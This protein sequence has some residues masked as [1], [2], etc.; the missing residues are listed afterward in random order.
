MSVGP[1]IKN[2]THDIA[3]TDG[4]QFVGL[5]GSA[6]ELG[7]NP[8]EQTSLKTT[9]GNQSYSDLE[10]PYMVVAQDDWTGGRAS[11]EFERDVTRYKDGLRVNTERAGGVILYGRETYC[12][13]LRDTDESLPGSMRLIP[14]TESRRYLSKQF[15]AGANKDATE[16]WFWVRRKGT[17]NGALTIALYSD[18]SG[19]IDSELQSTTLAVTDLDPLVSEHKIFS[20]T[21]E[22]ITD[23]TDYWVLIAGA[24]GDDDSD[25]WE[26]GASGDSGTTKKSSDG[27]TWASDTIDLYFRV[28]EGDTQTGGFWIEYKKGWYFITRPNDGTTASKLYLNGSR[29]LA[30]SNAGN[31][32]KLIASAAHGLTAAQATGAVVM[33]IEGTGSTEEQNWR[34]ITGVPT[35]TQFSVDKDWLIEHDATTAWVVLGTDV[36]TEIDWSANVTKPVT[37]AYVSTQAIAYFCQGEEDN[38]VRMKEEVDGGAWVRTFADD[39]VT[40]AI[41]LTEYNNAGTMYLVG[42]N[43]DGK[44]K[45]GATPTSWANWAPAA[46]VAV[47]AKWDRFTGAC[48]YKDYE[49]E[50]IAVLFKEGGPWQWK[51]EVADEMNTPEMAA[52]ASYK[53]GLACWRQSSYL[54]F[55]VQNTIWRFYNPNFDDVGP[56][57][58]EGLPVGRQGN[59][60]F[61]VAY[62][63]RIIVGID[64]GESGYSSVMVNSGGTAFHEM[65]R[66]PYG[67]RITAGAFQI[68]PGSEPDRLWIRQGADVV[69]LPFPSETYDPYQDSNYPF[70]HEFVLEL[71]DI[72]AGLYDAWKYWRSLKLRTLNLLESKTTGIRTTWLEC[73]YRTNE[74]DEWTTLREEFTVSP[75][76]EQDLDEE[77]G[78]SSQVIYMR[79]RGYSIDTSE[80]PKLTAA[81]ISGV[82]ITSPKFSYQT[83][84]ICSDRDKLGNAEDLEPWEKVKILDDW[85]GTARPLRL[86]STN[87]LYNNIAVFLM[88]LPVRPRA[89]AQLVNE[90]DYEVSLVLQEA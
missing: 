85:S 2:P 1:D 39:D 46:G 28:T 74:D 80:T 66:A 37:C 40:T 38:I 89:S 32:D 79:I 18:D 77:Y 16:L 90:H 59:I 88:P 5:L 33:V 20:I 84:A 17:P 4:K 72:T 86:Y 6:E 81:A 83:Q 73:D 13:G 44:A 9:T 48:P 23:D 15:E 35:T 54:Y 58:D 31:M 57:N 67:Q 26:V 69:Y 53:N 22:S 42:T 63:G 78:V 29:G 75:V 19:D 52:V 76:Q 87:P 65:Y 34:V 7:R 45:E 24:E 71:G 8:V 43:A 82:T 51:D 61:G 36:F 41:H 21:S 55:S 14:L 49:L 11:R 47:G 68:I 30:A 56:T 12:D 3:L 50:D 62:P 27:S 64:G 60:S 25:H 10:P 70:T